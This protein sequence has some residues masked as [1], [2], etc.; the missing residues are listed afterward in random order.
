MTNLLFHNYYYRYAEA[1]RS[2]KNDLVANNISGAAIKLDQYIT[3]NDNYI[4][5]KNVTATFA[6]E[7][8]KMLHHAQE[9]TVY[10][11]IP[12]QKQAAEDALEI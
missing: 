10:G 2:I 3:E 4:A 1:R 11:T 12:E 6:I 9:H 5:T 8:N 7:E